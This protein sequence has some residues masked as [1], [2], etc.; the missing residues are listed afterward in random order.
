VQ[1]QV[2]QYIIST[3]T[4]H[5][6]T[7]KIVM[8]MSLLISLLI[9]GF[10]NGQRYNGYD[11]IASDLFYLTNYVYWNNKQCDD[12]DNLVIGIY[13]NEPSGMENLE[14]VLVNL[15]KRSGYSGW[16]V[17]RYKNIAAIDNCQILFI[18]NIV[19][20][21]EL[22]NVL[23]S[24]SGKTVLTVGESIDHFCQV[25]G[26]ITFLR[27]DPSGYRFVINLEAARNSNIQIRSD[28]LELKIIKIIKQ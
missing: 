14:A 1:L 23:K 11:L 21:P 17:K 6:N 4:K 10:V 26:M 27:D 25:G 3:L 12:I 8:P 7:Y 22:S 20:Q 19:R 9:A 13:D 16:Q 15:L 28:F 2:K 24:V 5:G 18:P